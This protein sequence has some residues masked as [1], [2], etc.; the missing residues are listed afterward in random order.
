MDYAQQLSLWG[1]QLWGEVLPVGIELLK[2]LAAPIIALAALRV[3]RQQVRINESK[4]RLDMYD[5]RLK[6]YSAVK[7]LLGRFTANA[8][9]S[10]DD[11]ATFRD[12]VLE[13]DFL[14]GEEIQAYVQELDTK[15]RLLIVTHYK[16]ARGHDRGGDSAAEQL[17]KIDEID[18]WFIEQ[19][20][21]AK[22]VFGFHLRPEPTGK[23]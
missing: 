4:L 19:H 21:V 12:Q 6:I 20:A 2:A 7:E 11:L 10:Q 13:V 22:R 5:R 3:S 23:V 18:G 8:V 16:Y 14:F 9:I 1:Q 15:A 17:D